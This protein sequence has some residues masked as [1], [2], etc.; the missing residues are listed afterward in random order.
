M[1]KFIQKGIRFLGRKI[2]KVLVLGDRMV[3]F[4]YC[5]MKCIQGNSICVEIIDFLLLDGLPMKM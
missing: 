4:C 2:M 1:G 5:F 3:V